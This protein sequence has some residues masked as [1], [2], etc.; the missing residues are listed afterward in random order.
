VRTWLPAL[1]AGAGLLGC[2]GALAPA[3]HDVAG[4]FWEAVRTGDRETA[5]SLASAASALEVDQLTAKRKIAEVLL[6]ETLQSE[7][8]AIVRTS[9]QT[10]TDGEPLRAS[11]DTHLVR[12]GGQ[13][14][15]DVDATERELTSAL[16]A[17]SM[18]EIGEALGE[19][20]QEFS[21]ALEQ[22]VEE[23]K[24]ALREALEEMEQDLQ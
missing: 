6:G 9:L 10:E 5:L 11:F 23:M 7:T 19:G 12:E 20:A 1:L 13:W 3:P 24:E 22:G 18:R 16:F 8:S 4:R 14:K 15:V 21:K 17:A 2:S